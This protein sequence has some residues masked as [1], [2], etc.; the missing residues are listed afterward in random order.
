MQKCRN[1]ITDQLKK[2]P[3]GYYLGSLKTARSRRY[4]AFGPAT[5]AALKSHKAWMAEEQLRLGPAKSPTWYLDSQLPAPVTTTPTP[6]L[7]FH[8]S[9]P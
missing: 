5:V 6:C 7:C 4:I 8:T 3:D 9:Q 2:G 1:F